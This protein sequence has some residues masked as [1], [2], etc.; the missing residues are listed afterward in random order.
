MESLIKEVS[1]L[2]NN[3]REL[4]NEKIKIQSQAEHLSQQLSLMQTKNQD[5]DANVISLVR[6]L[7]SRDTTIAQLT[8]EISNLKKEVTS[9]VTIVRIFVKYIL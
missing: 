8:I 3:L 1:N 2:E 6:E 4:R 5:L 9:L 7:R